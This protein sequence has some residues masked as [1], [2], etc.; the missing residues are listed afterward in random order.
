VANGAENLAGIGAVL[1]QGMKLPM[2]IHMANAVR[3]KR[4]VIPMEQ[5]CVANLHMYRR[6][7]ASPVKGR[8]WLF[9]ETPQSHPI[10]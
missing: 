2:S 4:I 3:L 9:S 10:R 8:A 1:P 5:S 7:A 6:A